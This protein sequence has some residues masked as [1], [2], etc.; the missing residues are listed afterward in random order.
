MYETYL[1]VTEKDLRK[2]IAQAYSSMFDIR[3]M[4]YKAQNDIDLSG[5]CI[6]VVIQKQIASDESG[7]GFS[8]NPLNN[9]FDEI[10]GFKSLKNPV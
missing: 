4:G 7:V 9:C 10:V 5:T 1:G 2:R 6:S 8:L 3:V